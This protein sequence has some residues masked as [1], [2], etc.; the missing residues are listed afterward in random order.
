MAD[1]LPPDV[2]LTT[3]DVV[4]EPTN[5]FIAGDDQIAGMDDSTLAIAQAVHVMLTT[6]RYNHQ[7]Y[8]GNFGVEFHDLIGK[9]RDYIQ[10]TF[11][12]RVRDALMI[13]DRIVDVQNFVFTFEGDKAT[14]TFNVITVYGTISEVV[15][16]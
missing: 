10:V 12:E 15:Q 7:I 6:E 16:I 2:D 3:L 13:D 5:T 8:S 1:L 9:D 14:I 11:P 4:S